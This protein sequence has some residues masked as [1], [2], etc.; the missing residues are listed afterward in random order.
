MVIQL[1]NRY[2]QVAKNEKF[3]QTIKCKVH[4]SKSLKNHLTCSVERW[5]KYRRGFESKTS[6]ITQETYF[7]YNY[8]NRQP[9]RHNYGSNIS[10]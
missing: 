7:S 5:H 4:P 2:Y 1:S 6:V 3:T 8:I 10:T 9:C